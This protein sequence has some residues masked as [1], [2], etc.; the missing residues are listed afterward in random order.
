M[1]VNT[2]CFQNVEYSAKGI[3]IDM[4]VCYRCGKPIKGKMVNQVPS[5]LQIRL[6]LDFPKSFHPS[7]YQKTEAEAGKEL[8][9]NLYLWGKKTNMKNPGTTWHKNK[10]DVAVNPDAVWPKYLITSNEGVDYSGM[11]FADG[12]MIGR[13]DNKPLKQ[14]SRF[15]PGMK[16]ATMAN[17]SIGYPNAAEVQQGDVAV[18]P[19]IMDTKCEICGKPLGPEVFLSKYPV[20]GK[21][22]REQHR[23]V[24]KGKSPLQ[25]RRNPVRYVYVI[26]TPDGR[27]GSSYYKDEAI[28]TYK[29]HG[30]DLYRMP[31]STWRDG[32]GGWDYTTY[33]QFAEKIT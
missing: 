16:T 24:T 5:I 14:V 9:Q 29:K 21:C 17:P 8:E 4:I 30:G 3:L 20:C 6:G 22:T 26:R 13:T 33:I 10:S 19:D 15:Y 28:R 1:A 7:C 18:N 25:K 27:I 31:L 12:I 11:P 23:R 32:G 2:H